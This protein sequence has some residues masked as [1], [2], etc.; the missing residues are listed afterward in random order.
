MAVHA[1]ARGY[2]VAVHTTGIRRAA[3]LLLLKAGMICTHIDSH[4]QAYMYTFMKASKAC[5]FI[6]RSTAHAA[7]SEAAPTVSWKVVDEVRLF[8]LTPERTVDMKQ[9]RERHDFSARQADASKL[10]MTQRKGRGSSM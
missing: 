9:D 8:A 5:G 4:T 6:S 2:K 3:L 10:A 1:L 7:F